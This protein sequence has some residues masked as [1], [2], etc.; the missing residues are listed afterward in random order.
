[1]PRYDPVI[2]ILAC[3][4]LPLAMLS[5]PPE[6]DT[7]THQIDDMATSSGLSRVAHHLYRDWLNQ[8]A[9]QL[10]SVDLDAGVSYAILGACDIDCTAL[11]FQLIRPDGTLF[12]SG[13]GSSARPVLNVE[14]D[15]G[16]RYQL[17]ATMRQCRIQPCEWGVRVYRR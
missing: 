8:G 1:M 5:N 11:G 7:I 12:A 9:H 13:T 4:L 6:R 14:P 10:F 17:K 15:Q 3:T 2:A 16:G